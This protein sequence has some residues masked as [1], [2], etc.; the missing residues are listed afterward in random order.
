MSIIQFLRIFWARRALIV[1]AAISCLVGG[2]IVGAVMP[3]RWEAHS[4]VLLNLLKPDPVTG[5]VVTGAGTN[6]YIATQL[7]LVQD[8]SVA[9]EVVDQLG[10]LSDP[11]LIAAYQ[12][13]PKGD[14]KDFRR[15]A[16]Q[17][18]MDNT[19]GTLVAGSNILDISYTSDRQDNA[20][21]VADAVQKAYIDSSLAFHR[22]DASRNAD[23]YAQQAQQ[24]KVAL[25]SAS[26]DKDVYEK[27][28]GL[29]LQDNKLSVESARLAAL[30]GQGTYGAPMVAP[31]AQASAAE[32]QLAMVDAQIASDSK[33][34][35]PNH[36]EIVGLRSRRAAL[37]SEAAQERAASGSS[38]AMAQAASAGIGAL[39]R[40]VAEQKAKVI[41]EGDKVEHLRQLQAVVDMRADQYASAMSKSAT[42]RQDAGVSD[43]GLTPL[44]SAVSPTSPAF[45]NWWLIIPGSLALGLGVGVL[46]ALL[47]ELFARKVRGPEDLQSTL[48]VPLLA[49]I[50]APPRTKSSGLLGRR[51]RGVMK[52]PRGRRM[53]PA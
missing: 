24:A 13:R 20:K 6:A 17:R 8:Y 52:W 41:S 43:T 10:W 45:P 38:R 53:L 49:V 7:Q 39:N 3:P 12:K 50:M 37:A 32:Q 40:A 34:L 33:I 25:D 19:K 27:A 21:A 11:Q 46:V 36:P 15:W 18:V 44:G 30:A 31:A 9:G 22:A 4:R 26:A 48:D 14:T 29:V 42:M 1:A 23:W 5:M 2:A 28:N 51:P 47:A 16:A 35:G